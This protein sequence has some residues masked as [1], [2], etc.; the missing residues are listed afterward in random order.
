MSPA[1]FLQRIWARLSLAQVEDVATWIQ[2]SLP[3]APA[4][5][6]WGKLSIT[7]FDSLWGCGPLCFEELFV[8]VIVKKGKGDCIHKDYFR[9][10]LRCYCLVRLNCRWPKC[11]SKLWKLL[12]DPRIGRE[13]VLLHRLYIHIS[14]QDSKLRDEQNNVVPVEERVTPGGQK[15]STFSPILQCKVFLSLSLHYST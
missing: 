1:P 12:T 3:A 5:F 11:K 2:C 6:F 4:V 7:S 15:K 9:W 8:L 14:C 13:L 10:A